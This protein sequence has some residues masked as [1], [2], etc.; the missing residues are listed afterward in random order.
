MYY[1]NSSD[2]YKSILTTL[3]SVFIYLFTSEMLIKMFAL[4]PAMYFNDT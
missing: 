3:D 4:G 1:E 2:T